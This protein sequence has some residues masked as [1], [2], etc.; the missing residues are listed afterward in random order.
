MSIPQETICYFFAY[1]LHMV[2][3]TSVRSRRRRV[4]VCFIRRGLLSCNSD[5]RCVI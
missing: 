4:W 5:C 2:M 3:E 1:P